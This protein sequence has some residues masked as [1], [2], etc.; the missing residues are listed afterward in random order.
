M[1][2]LNGGGGPWELFLW[3][4]YRA[5]VVWWIRGLRHVGCMWKTRMHTNNAFK[6]EDA[7]TTK[8]VRIQGDI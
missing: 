1:H 4:Q 7:L 8:Y 6:K 2:F 3:P 5:L